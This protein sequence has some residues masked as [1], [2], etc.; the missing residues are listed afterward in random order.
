M[1]CSNIEKCIKEECPYPSD[2]PVFDS[3]IREL[4]GYCPL[5]DMYFDEEKQ[6]EYRLSKIPKN[7]RRVGQQKGWRRGLQ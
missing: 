7:K 3:N 4:H 1:T 5:V 2:N 6:E